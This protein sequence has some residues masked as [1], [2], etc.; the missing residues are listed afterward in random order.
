MDALVQ[1]GLGGGALALLYAFGKPLLSA[2]LSTL[3]QVGESM[4]SITQ[5]NAEIV[6]TLREDRAN[7]EQRHAE[8]MDHLRA[9]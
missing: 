6:R 3:R 1:L 8:I 2:H 5:S 9:S 4:S 7:A